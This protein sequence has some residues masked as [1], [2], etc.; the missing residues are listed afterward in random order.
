V[1][2]RRS[3]IGT[4]EAWKQWVLVSIAVRYGL[5]WDDISQLS[6]AMGIPDPYEMARCELA[7]DRDDNPLHR[8][9]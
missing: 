7:A 3:E 6:H 4:E 9:G 2:E 5:R 8:G 1:L